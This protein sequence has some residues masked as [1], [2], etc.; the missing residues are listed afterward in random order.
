MSIR[1]WYGLAGIVLFLLSCSTSDEYQE[2]SLS[3]ITV[4]VIS[5]N[6]YE[7]K[8]KWTRPGGDTD[9]HIVYKVYLNEALVAENINEHTFTFDELKGLTEYQG[10]VVAV[11]A[12][13]ISTSA[14]YNFLTGEKTY[15]GNVELN[16][17]GQVEEFAESGYNVIKGSLILKSTA[18]ISDLSALN[19]LNQVKGDL[20]IINT[21]LQNLSGL[22]NLTLDSE[23]ARLAILNNDR[24]TDIEAL[25]NITDLGILSVSGNELLQNLNGL[26]Q[27]HTVKSE[28]SL[29]VNPALIN[30]EALNRLTYAHKVNIVANNTLSDLDG[31]DN[32]QEV[33]SFVIK[34]NGSLS[35]LE[36]LKNL[37]HCELY[38][39]VED[40]QKLTSLNGL[41]SLASTG[42]LKI[43]NNPSL[44]NIADLTELKSVDYLIAINHNLSLNSLNGLQNAVFTNS[45]TNKELYINNNPKLIDLEALSAQTFERGTIKISNNTG[46]VNFCGLKKLLSEI[47]YK[48]F[49]ENNFI[50]NNGYNPDINQILN[51]NC[52]L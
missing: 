42:A 7:S 33:N 39:T 21:N 18:G 51:N 31:L 10:K 29:S 47:K 5:G 11:N 24:L 46:L 30:I 6:P 41:S 44:E 48:E 35:N 13:G 19:T 45:L 16:D 1:L 34:S 36:G 26:N 15:E 40:N 2:P 27:L 3:E 49:D 32:L 22:E 20:L 4:E 37:K 23:E 9:Q 25:S 8:I 14:E 17:Q 43:I 38:F 52:A 12:D 50:I 28:L